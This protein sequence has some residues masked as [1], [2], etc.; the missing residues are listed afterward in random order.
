MLHA[1]NRTQHLETQVN[2]S[3]RY[4]PDPGIGSLKKQLPEQRT[5]KGQF[6]MSA[7]ETGRMR[8][9]G[10]STTA[11]CDPTARFLPC[12]HSP[13]KTPN[14]LWQHSPESQQYALHLPAPLPSTRPQG[15]SSHPPAWSPR[16]SSALHQEVSSKTAI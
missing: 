5:L 16:L 15:N 14:L 13:C 12:Y 11:R 9:S 2:K 1:C 4:H 3:S 7:E 8:Q 6:H 10:F